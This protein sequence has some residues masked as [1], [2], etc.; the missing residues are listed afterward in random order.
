MFV[1]ITVWSITMQFA[2]SGENELRLVGVALV[3]AIVL[4]L[5]TYWVL[6][7]VPAKAD[8]YDGDR[9]RLLTW[10]I[11]STL[12]LYV[13]LPYIQ[14]YQNSG[15]LQFPYPE[16]YRYSWNNF[17]IGLVGSFV[18]G[19]YWLLVELCAGLFRALGV[20]V[21]QEMVHRPLFV[22]VTLSAMMGLGIGM[23]KEN[24]RIINALR[25]IAATVFRALL[26]LLVVIILAFL[27]TLPFTGLQPLW[28]TK[29]ASAILLSVLLLTILFINAVFQDGAVVIPYGRWLQR[30]VEAVLFTMP[31]VTVLTAYSIGLRIAQHS[32]TPDRFYVVLFVV[33]TGLYGLGYT[34]AIL[35][36]QEIWL[37][38]LRLVNIG[39][40]FVVVGLALLAHTPVLDP[41][42]WSADNQYQRLLTGRVSAAEFD[43]GALRFELGHLGYAKL[44]ALGTLENHPE[45]AVIAQQLQAV[46]QVKHYYEWK[47]LAAKSGK[48]QLTVGDLQVLTPSGQLPDGLLDQLRV[49]NRANNSEVEECI[50]GKQCVVV[51]S[52][53][54]DDLE[55]EYVFV[56]SG[57]TST[58]F[59]T[60][61]LYGQGGDHTWRR[62]GTVHFGGEK[63]RYDRAHLIEALRQGRV[64]P[65][66][67]V[68]K[69]LLIEQ[70]KICNEYV[71]E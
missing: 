67:P 41:L 49:A 12:V 68:Y 14:I 8:L 5:V 64:R 18:T 65:A 22:M 6:G 40:S 26:P 56:T 32:I 69:C 43:Y 47:Q 15:R 51:S 38:L 46:R 71:M 7:Q 39:M 37:G 36:S 30:G 27:L 61:Y 62:I 42:R 54:D 19:L 52:N 63:A 60:A 50:K 58:R 31:V 4:G 59:F 57:M 35:R 1:F 55:K 20:T 48:P 44:Q 53:L 13:L 3:K 16:L 29:W 24:D 10:S 33:V 34:A 21:V 70:D 23:G 9:Y 66:Q 25:T 11:G 45:K 17:F 28:D 2:R